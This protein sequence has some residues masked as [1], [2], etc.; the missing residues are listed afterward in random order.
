MQLR[1][2]EPR[3]L[4]LVADCSRK[5]SGFG[6]SLILEGNEV[7][8]PA[9]PAAIGC[10]AHIVDF[11][12][13][14][15]GLLNLQVQGG[16]RL[17]IESSRVR[18]NGLIVAHI[19]WLDDPPR[20]RIGAEHELLCLLLR[21][22][23]ERAGAPHDPDDKGLFEDAAWVGWRLAEWLPLTAQQ[24]QALLQSSDPHARLQQL[25]EWIPDFQE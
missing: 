4:D 18:D 15:D 16:R 21:R 9:A 17:R 11:S 19:A 14:A 2:F 20:E 23:V 1:I 10:E 12:S 7:G 3:Y 25:V 22:I 13:G 24:R 5:A 8:A 6:I